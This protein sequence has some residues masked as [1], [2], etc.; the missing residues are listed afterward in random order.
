MNQKN[1]FLKPVLALGLF[2]LG[3]CGSSEAVDTGIPINLIAPEGAGFI[4]ESGTPNLTCPNA[5]GMT[6]KDMMARKSYTPADYTKQCNLLPD[7]T[8]TAVLYLKV[9]AFDLQVCKQITGK[10][11]ILN[12]DEC[13]GGIAPSGL[14]TRGLGLNFKLYIQPGAGGADVDVVNDDP[15]MPRVVAGGFTAV[16]LYFKLPVADPAKK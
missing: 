10:T 12:A 15:T 9:V 4:A 16:R 2:A 5:T 1:R 7:A 13:I 14:T 8:G 3:A 11:D 6:P